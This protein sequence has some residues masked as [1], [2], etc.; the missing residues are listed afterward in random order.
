M[1]TRRNALR[2]SINK[3]RNS[4]DAGWTFSNPIGRTEEE[5]KHDKEITSAI[6]KMS[7][8]TFG[9]Y[10]NRADANFEVPVMLY[11]RYGMP[12]VFG[13]SSVALIKSAIYNVQHVYN[14]FLQKKLD[15]L[16]DKHPHL[17][18]WATIEFSEIHRDTPR[19]TCE[20]VTHNI[21]I[22]EM[23]RPLSGFDLIDKWSRSQVEIPLCALAH[24]Y[25]DSCVM[26]AHYIIV[27]QTRK[28]T[29]DA[30]NIL[31]SLRSSVP[32]QGNKS[33]LSCILARMIGSRN[34][35]HIM[36]NFMID[37]MNMLDAATRDSALESLEYAIF[38]EEWKI[39]YLVFT[40]F[41]QEGGHKLEDAAMKVFLLR[42]YALEQ[43]LRSY[44]E[45]SCDGY[46]NPFHKFVRDL[47]IID[48]DR[49][50]Y[51]HQYGISI[52]TMRRYINEY[53]T[54]LKS[55]PTIGEV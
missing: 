23:C 25:Y 16:Y 42:V 30:H 13:S 6:M 29:K 18:A 21:D 24:Y 12:A 37:H 9:E 20:W 50:E 52:N 34:T 19:R 4:G 41:L 17:F 28:Q 47:N 11:D 54:L 36:K 35:F 38:H 45:T 22:I 48:S 55:D 27:Q 14:G 2:S 1:S 7:P 40:E 39:G 31:E 49:L 32:T 53:N 46:S 8:E 3:S 33:V 44:R 15:M 51:V 43:P 5:C 26:I 10:L